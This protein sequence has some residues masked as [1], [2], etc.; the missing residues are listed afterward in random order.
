MH[1]ILSMLLYHTLYLITLPSVK[2]SCVSNFWW[3]G[4]FHGRYAPSCVNLRVPRGRKGN[5][6]GRTTMSNLSIL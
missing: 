1:I 5:G 4:F 6:D 2:F 3:L